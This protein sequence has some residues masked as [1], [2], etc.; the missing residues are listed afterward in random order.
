MLL[1]ISCLVSYNFE[2]E[3][4]LDALDFFPGL[5]DFLIVCCFLAH[6]LLLECCSLQFTIPRNGSNSSCFVF[7][8]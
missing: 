6:S 4:I 8:S 7:Y 3:P 5:G 1:I 2:F